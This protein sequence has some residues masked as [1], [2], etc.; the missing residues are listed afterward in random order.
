MGARVKEKYT[1]T[2]FCHLKGWLADSKKT[3]DREEKV[4]EKEMEDKNI[5]S[6]DKDEDCHTK[7]TKQTRSF[8]GRIGQQHTHANI[9]HNQFPHNNALHSDVGT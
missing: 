5:K 1:Y 4:E 7:K 9:K 3:E 2:Y 8:V 6:E